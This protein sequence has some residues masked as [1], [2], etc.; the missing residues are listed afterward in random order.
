MLCRLGKWSSGIKSH[1]KIN[2]WLSQDFDPGLVNSGALVP[3]HCALFLPGAWVDGLMLMDAHCTFRPYFLSS[4]VIWS[5]GSKGDSSV[6]GYLGGRPSRQRRRQM[7]DSFTGNLDK[8][9]W[10][11]LNFLRN[12]VQA[13]KL[14]G[15]IANTHIRKINLSF[16]RGCMS[17]RIIV[18]SCITELPCF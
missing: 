7:E 1:T 16:L 5:H 2:K 3:N 8:V 13:T 9:C 10:Q 6:A 17:H 11:P 12:R 18:V 15:R 4:M 14:W